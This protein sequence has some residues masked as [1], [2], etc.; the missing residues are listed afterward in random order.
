MTVL[1]AILGLI[2]LI[3]VHELGHMFAAKGVG[4]RVTE[5]GVGF[6]P[7]LFKR[8]FG[9]TIYSFRIILLGGFAKMAGMNDDEEGP[10]TYDAKPAWRRAFIIFAG[11]L[12]NLIAAV[13]IFAGIFMSG[14]PEPTNAVAEVVPGT[15]AAEAG[16]EP[17]DRIVGIEGREIS[18]WREFVSI[19]GGYSIGDRV[20]LVVERGGE[21]LAVSGTLSASEEDPERA[22][23]GVRSEVV[24]R[25][26]GPV[27]AAGLAVEQ[28][29]RIIGVFGIFIGQL[30]G[31]Q[32]GLYE[33]V[34]SPI[35]VVSVS[36]DIAAQG[37]FAFLQLLAFIS[38][39]LAVFNLL[40]VLPLDGGHLLF[41]AAE[42]VFGRRVSAETLQRAAAIGFMLMMMLF[43]FAIYADVSKILS[44]QPFIPE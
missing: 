36:S 43:L 10:D 14:V 7:A 4:V 19:V 31:G 33:S 41:I 16:V 42:K 30:V 20:D 34:N 25:S 13:V 24:E 18:S 8:R 40:P 27:A 35:G 21:R 9:K 5:F 3:I 38:I 6:G 23:V 1:V 28:V 39:N 2:M 44:G 12:A 22:I 17:G 37:S 29:V 26:Y 15:L 11:P 32:I